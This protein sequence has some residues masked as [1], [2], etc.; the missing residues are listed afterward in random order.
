MTGG[1]LLLHIIGFPKK[2]SKGYEQF[3]E[4][5]K[6]AGHPDKPAN[7]FKHFPDNG[8]VLVVLDAEGK[9]QPMLSETAIPSTGGQVVI[10][11]ANGHYHMLKNA[12]SGTWYLYEWA[13]HP[14]TKA[15]LKKY[16]PNADE[17]FLGVLM[18]VNPAY[19]RALLSAAILGTD[20][21]QA[22]AA[23]RETGKWKTMNMLA[24]TIAASAGMKGSDFGLG[25]VIAHFD[26][27]LKALAQSD[28][29]K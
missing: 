18:D 19:N 21:R 20:P 24:T 23:F 14:T 17:R 25:T 2:G 28:N 13:K 16:F 22:S 9:T 29:S 27:S 7:M 4:L 5:R 11:L 1:G 3:H 6:K 10:Q 15:A 26:Q 12:G 8:I